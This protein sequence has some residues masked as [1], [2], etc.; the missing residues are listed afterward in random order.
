MKLQGHLSVLA[1][2]LLASGPALSHGD[3]H[4]AAG[5]TR[6]DY[7]KAEAKPFGIAVDPRKARRTITMTMSDRMR[8]TPSEL[9]IRQGESVRFV[10][11]NG[12]KLLH[13]MVLGTM[14]DLKEHAELMK[15]PGHFEA[16]MIGKIIVTP[17]KE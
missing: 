1:L 14:E 9:R 11:R 5:A 2:L 3:R 4:E 6:F 16:G 7:S 17:A 8:F 15:K 12:G 10:V 13:E